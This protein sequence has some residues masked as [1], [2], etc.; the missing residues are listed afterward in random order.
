MCVDDK[1]LI[2]SD[3][4]FWRG[5]ISYSNF[6]LKFGFLFFSVFDSIAHAL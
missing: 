5:L 2:N 3:V 4:I 6:L 1:R